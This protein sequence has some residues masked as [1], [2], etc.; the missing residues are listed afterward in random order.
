MKYKYLILVVPILL[1]LSGSMV[2]ADLTKEWKQPATNTTYETYKDT[3]TMDITLNWNATTDKPTK[4]QYI[5]V[6]ESI[7]TTFTTYYTIG[8]L[9]EVDGGYN[10]IPSEGSNALN[11][12][13]APTLGFSKEYLNATDTKTLRT[14]VKTGSPIE[15]NSGEYGYISI[16]VTKENGNVV[17]YT[18]DLTSTLPD[19]EIKFNKDTIG[20]A[21]L[22]STEYDAEKEGKY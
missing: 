20:Y 15:N 9:I 14:L 6:D 7:D 10:Y 2:S 22:C 3:I 11:V 12:N 13:K 19:S 5:L 8:E 1:L 17:T 21:F 18:K 16:E 4:I